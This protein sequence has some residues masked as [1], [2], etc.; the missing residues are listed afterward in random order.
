MNS[1]GPLMNA[2]PALDGII[3]ATHD[4]GSNPVRGEA[5]QTRKETHLCWS[6][7]FGP[8]AD[9][10]RKQEE[11]GALIDRQLNQ[12][13]PRLE[14]RLAQRLR[15]GRGRAMEPVERDVK[16]QIRCVNETKRWQ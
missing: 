16:V 4:E 1:L 6:G 2:H 13:V 14:R 11:C 8:I 3:V 10:A 5:L 7:S 12:G 15:D 9:V